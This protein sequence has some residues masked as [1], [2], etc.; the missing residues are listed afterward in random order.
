MKEQVQEFV[1]KSG[2]Q[3]GYVVE[4]DGRLRNLT[5]KCAI[6]VFDASGKGITVWHVV[7]GVAKVVMS[8]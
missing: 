7:K 5:R 8:K 6:D 3:G 4:K 1:T 2:I